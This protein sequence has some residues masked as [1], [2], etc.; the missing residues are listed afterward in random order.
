M[1]WFIEGSETETT[2]P[3]AVHLDAATRLEAERFAQRHHINVTT[4]WAEQAIAPD[5]APDWHAPPPRFCSRCHKPLA[6]GSVH[7]LDFHPL[8][9]I[10]LAGVEEPPPHVRCG[11]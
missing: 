8:C 7:S 11:G 1:R 9:A 2:T 5:A 4:I 10:C 3:V 6:A